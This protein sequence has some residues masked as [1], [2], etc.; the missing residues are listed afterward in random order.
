MEYWDVYDADRRPLGKT[1]LRGMPMPSGEY[2]LVVFVWVVNAAGQLLLTKRSPE[3]QA[4]PNMW[5]NTGGSAITGESSRQAIR[6]ELFE[7]TGIA[8]E[9]AEFE[10][11]GTKVGGG[12]IS[13]TYLLQRDVPLSALRFQAGETCDARWVTRAE[14]DALTAQ[15]VVAQPDVERLPLVWERLD[16]I[17]R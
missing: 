17:F 15:G 13:D 3:K 9:E 2:H 5:A 7:E 10:F 11:L 6:R 4:Y 1:H 16:G 12:R 8:A 14:F